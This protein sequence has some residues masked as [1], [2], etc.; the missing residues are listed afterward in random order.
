MG[1]DKVRRVAL[2]ARR[3]GWAPPASVLL[4]TT[5]GIFLAEL[6][7]M[8]VIYLLPELNYVVQMFIDAAIMTA[9]IFPVIYF[10]SFR[11]LIQH[12]ERHRQNEQ[13][14][15]EVNR[16]LQALSMTEHNQRRWAE[17]LT[18]ATAA[19]SQSLDLNEILTRIL[20]QIGNVIPYQAGAVL[21]TEDE[22]VTVLRHRGF[23]YL[24]E[25]VTAYEQR[26]FAWDA[27]PSL[28][29]VR[30]SGRP[31]LVTDMASYPLRAGV[32]GFEWVQSFMV[33][34]FSRDGCL[35]GMI[36]L[37][38]SQTNF[39]NETDFARL[40][41]FT[42]H[43]EVA[44]A[45]ARLFE[46]ESRARKLADVLYTASTALAQSLDLD[47]VVKT[48][49]DYVAWLVP[50]DRADIALLEDSNR[51]VIRASKDRVGNRM[52]F[53][54]PTE[55]IAVDDFPLVQSLLCEQKSQ[56]IADTA[57]ISD[58]RH[59]REGA[60]MRSWLGVPLTTGGNTIGFCSL[61]KAEPDFFKEEHALQVQALA[62]QTAVM[63][64]KA[65]LFEQV[66][67]GS[68]RLQAL[69]RRL[70]EIQ[71]SER[72][73]IARELH[74]EA[75]QALSAMSM[76]LRLLEQNSHR[77][78]VILDCVAKMDGT[79]QTTIA[80]LHR[81]AM[82]LRPA[83]L[84]HLGLEAALR[85]HVEDVAYRHGLTIDFDCSGLVRNLHQNVETTLYRIVQ[86]ALTNIVRHARATQ[87]DVMLKVRS[88]QLVLVVE[89]NGVGFDPFQTM[90]GE[91]LGL[92]GMRE[93]AEMLNG[94]LTIESAPGK[95]ATI[96]V[97]IPY[98]Y[99]DSDH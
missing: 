94:Q 60:C 10:L 91:R 40:I 15:Q 50:F 36:V 82:A 45:N 48:S 81:L 96:V 93:R 18:E 19:L 67:T 56:W 87:V 64:Q 20:V 26:G 29:K 11:E 30:D 75:G 68:E 16:N 28:L 41:S 46:R 42:S 12:I 43:A 21:L 39:F 55:P 80:S 90:P 58:W 13:Q 57:E 51:L 3:P 23:D 77:P 17:A 37:L 78:E 52:V 9:L 4:I 62:T 98:V 89:D 53:Q 73:Y 8:V 65:W 99:P 76:D 34:P 59:F 14:L 7:A 84:D 70:V 2:I 35:I 27:F 85:Q 24:P 54:S 72:N 86:E 6:V 66:R 71:E 92:L 95:G 83:A 97:E 44:I 22:K 33:T 47:V 79:L 63:I 49:L 5:T 74:D 61:E 38:S 31:I 25:A 32:S 69:S 1:P 88:D